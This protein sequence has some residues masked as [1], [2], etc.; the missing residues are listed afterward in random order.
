MGFLLVFQM[1]PRLK[2][3]VPMTYSCCITE[4]VTILNC[5]VIVQMAEEKPT[6]LICPYCAQCFLSTRNVDLFTTWM[7]VL[8]PV[9]YTPCLARAVES[10]PQSSCCRTFSWESSMFCCLLLLKY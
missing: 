2:K 9:A 7:P 10:S 3:F 5:I 6:F 8:D 4:L 1:H